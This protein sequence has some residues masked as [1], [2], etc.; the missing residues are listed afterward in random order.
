MDFYRRYALLSI[1]RGENTQR[2]RTD[3]FSFQRHIF[4]PCCIQYEGNSILA[5]AFSARGDT[6]I[7]YQDPIDA[8]YPKIHTSTNHGALIRD[9]YLRHHS[10]LLQAEAVAAIAL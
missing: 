4:T 8:I 6:L 3:Y 5:S 1:R 2:K 10:I 9:T 7:T